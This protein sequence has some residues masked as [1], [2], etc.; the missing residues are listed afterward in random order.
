VTLLDPACFTPWR[1]RAGSYAD[2][3]I[4]ARYDH[5]VAAKEILKK[6]TVGFCNAESLLC[7]PKDGCKA[8]MFYK[9]G[10]HFWCH[11]KNNEFEMVYES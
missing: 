2:F 6:H 1:W 3:G 9:D 8:V 5:I 7:R 11:M 4:I 10:F